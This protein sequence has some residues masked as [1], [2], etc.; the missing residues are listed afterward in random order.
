MQA[1]I[2]HYNILLLESNAKA[3]R[4]EIINMPRINN[5]PQALCCFSQAA[6]Q[7]IYSNGSKGHEQ[8]S[9]AMRS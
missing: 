9:A 6:K 1:N 3:R 4:N 5:K 2:A 7:H 8:L